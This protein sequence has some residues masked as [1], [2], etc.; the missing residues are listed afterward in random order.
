VSDAAPPAGITPVTDFDPV[1]NTV[2][3]AFEAY[4]KGHRSGCPISHS[5]AHGG[6]WL[7]TGYQAARTVL[8]D[9]E[10]FC[11]GGGVLFPDP[12]APKN[13][14]LEFDPTEHRALRAIFTGALTT[15]KVR[16]TG[17]RIQH[18]VEA[19]ID[20]FADRGSADLNADFAAPLTTQTIA[21]HIGIPDELLPRMQRVSDNIVR[22]L[23]QPET[24]TT[25]AA[26][27][28]FSAFALE[29]IQDRRENPRD[30]PLTVLARSEVDGRPLD[31]Q[32][33]VGHF[34]GF[35]IA[36][37]DTTRA[38]LCRLLDVLGRDQQLRAQ[39]LEDPSAVDRAVE[40]SLRLRPPFHFFRRTVA[41]P[42]DIEGVRLEAGEQVLVSFAAANR[43]PAGFDDPD[44]F[45]IDRSNRPHL[46]F[47]H[48]IH[49]CAGAALAR[50][51]LRFAVSGILC[52]IPDYQPSVF[53]GRYTERIPSATIRAVSVAGATTA[54]D[55]M[56]VEAVSR[57]R[58]RDPAV[59]L[60]V[61][62]AAADLYGELGWSGF[63]IEGVAR[64]AAVGKAS[65]YLR[66]SSREAL[67]GDAL[68]HRL[69]GIA[70][71]DTGTVRGD[72]T[73]LATQLVRLYMGQ[74]GRAALRIG[75]EAPAIPSLGEAWK[76]LQSSQVLAA[77]AMVR[78]GIKRGELP[79]STSVTIMLDCLTG[80]AM[81]HAI[82]SPPELHAGLAAS[83]DAYARQLVNFCLRSAER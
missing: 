57:G 41:A 52:R 79:D 56:S 63:S 59:E 4:A 6:F 62:E 26:I 34:T 35:L 16:A 30:D 49:L 73:E 25:Q 20:G 36:G 19:L 50:T 1:T 32:Q 18:R 43:D 23:E 75:I 45:R 53:T 46:T 13:A 2:A 38:S 31:A 64:R 5:D 27:A 7:V 82:A 68:L 28:E 37:H 47:G 22:S 29:L 80:G 51:Q 83:P 21:E 17:V 14:P 67:L 65:I 3:G 77:R 58:P 60:R 72:L 39:L 40:E 42:T 66:W 55:P 8:A 76:R 61:V 33:A 54:G 24:G 10:R 9:H 78:R 81:M 70:D 69:G 48:G 44:T 12:G 11:S 15:P 71:A 74:K